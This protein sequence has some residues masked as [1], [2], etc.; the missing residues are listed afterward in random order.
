MELV[1]CARA[2]R[3]RAVLESLHLSPGFAAAAVGLNCQNAQQKKGL[4]TK[5]GQTQT[6]T[7]HTD[8]S[9]K[10]WGDRIFRCKLW[11]D[12]FHLIFPWK[13]LNGRISIGKTLKKTTLPETNSL[14]LKINGWRT[15]VSFWAR[16]LFRCKLAV[17][18]RECCHNVDGSEIPNNHLRMVLKPYK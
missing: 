17:S 9:N 10:F 4:P 5:I 8:F 13:I 2:S 15:I 12:D 18:S 6:H 14:P 7:P 16:H 11:M 1:G 3:L